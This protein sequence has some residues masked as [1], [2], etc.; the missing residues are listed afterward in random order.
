MAQGPRGM[1]TAVLSPASGRGGGISA[2][3]GIQ[4]GLREESLVPGRAGHGG[5]VQEET[6]CTYGFRDP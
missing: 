6:E 1:C 3:K 2:S 4:A 5:A